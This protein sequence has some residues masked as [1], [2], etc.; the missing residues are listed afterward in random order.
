M[1]AWALAGGLEALGSFPARDTI[2]GWLRAGGIEGGTFTEEGT[3]QGGLC[4]AAHNL[5]RGQRLASQSS[6]SGFWFHSVRSA[7][8]TLL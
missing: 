7:V 8:T 5:G 2:A 6:S 3:P 1:H 4:A